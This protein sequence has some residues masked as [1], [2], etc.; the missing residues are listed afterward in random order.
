MVSDETIVKCVTMAVMALIVCFALLV[1]PTNNEVFVLAVAA[2]A[3]ISGFTFPS[4]L[5]PTQPQAPKQGP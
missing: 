5:F 2:I 4:G 3:G 1:A